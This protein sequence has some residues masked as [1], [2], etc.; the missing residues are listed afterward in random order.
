MGFA[1]RERIV[2][3]ER[4]ALRAEEFDAATSARRDRARA[5]PRRTAPGSSPLR[6]ITSRVCLVIGRAQI[7]AHVKPVL[8]A[9][10]G[11]GKGAAAVGEGD[12]QFRES[13]QTRRRKSSSRSRAMFRPACRRATAASISACAPC[14]PCP[15]DERRW[16]RRVVRP[17]SRRAEAMRYPDSELSMRPECGFASTCVP[18]C[19]P[20]NPNSRT[21]RSNSPAARSGSCI[22]IV[23][24]PANLFGCSRTTSAM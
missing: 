17:R 9:A 18:I 11:E 8:D 20:R 4:N 23:A 1:E 22:G 2:G 24:R 7:R 21:H 12:A 3:A 16:R 19:A 15:M 10:D 6:E 14:R 13:A 5:S